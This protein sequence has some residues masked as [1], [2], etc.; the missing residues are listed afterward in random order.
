MYRGSIPLNISFA[1]SLLP[2]QMSVFVIPIFFP[3]LPPSEQIKTEFLCAT[4]NFLLSK[5]IRI[6]FL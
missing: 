6:P 3:A 2:K 5:G 1:I 4:L